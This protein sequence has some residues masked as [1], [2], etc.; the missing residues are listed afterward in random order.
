MSAVQ[1]VAWL[2]IST[3]SAELALNVGIEERQ[4]PFQQISI[5]Y[6]PVLQ[7]LF[8][9]NLIYLDYVVKKI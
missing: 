9:L 1:T 4:E 5:P 7:N 3:K 6:D 2:C 8:L